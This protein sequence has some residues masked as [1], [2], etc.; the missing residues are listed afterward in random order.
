[1]SPAVTWGRS[2]FDGRCHAFPATG[3]DAPDV[4]AVCS[5]TLPTELLSPTGGPA[6]S[7]CYSC[8]VV[9]ARELPGPNAGGPPFP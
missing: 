8:A 6:G 9:V 7:L 1:M 4:E 5:H 3:T 2:G